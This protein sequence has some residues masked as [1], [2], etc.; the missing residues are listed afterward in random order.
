M[1]IAKIIQSI[2]TERDNITSHASEEAKNDLLMIDDIFFATCHGKIIE[3]YPAD[4]PYPSY[5]IFGETIDGKPV[6]SV[7]A[8]DQDDKIAVLVTVYRP[9]SELWDEWVIR[10]KQ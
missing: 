8:F 3:K 6:H 7:W 5:L 10:K 4:K 2:E 1:E 9:H